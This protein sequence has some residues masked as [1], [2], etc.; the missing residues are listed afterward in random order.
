MQTTTPVNLRRWERQPAIVPIGL[1][2]KTDTGPTLKA[3]HYQ[4]DDSAL[5]VDISLHGV[6]VRTV[7]ALVPGEWVGVIP[8]AEF[9]FA[10]HARVVWVREDESRHSTYAGIELL[11]TLGA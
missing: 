9:P 4:T 1:A 3:N 2:L 6:R 8:D 5:T 7:L 10:V 11:G